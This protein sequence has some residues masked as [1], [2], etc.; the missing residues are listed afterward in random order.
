MTI[1]IIIS[2]II[3]IIAFIC[4]SFLCYK[5]A[6]QL[7]EIKDKTAQKREEIVDLL[8]KNNELIEKNTQLKNEIIQHKSFLIDYNQKE[9][10]KIEQI[11]NNLEN[12]YEQ[13]CV[14]LENS[15]KEE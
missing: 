2:T 1:A 9:N 5:S 13:Y 12:A 3:A 14:L 6:S 15:Y 11:K 4:L 8:Q 7:Q 10:E